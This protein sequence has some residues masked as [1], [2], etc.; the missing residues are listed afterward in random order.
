MK[1]LV[2]PIHGSRLQV[3]TIAIL[4]VGLTILGV[5]QITAPPEY[6]Q[7]RIG[8]E[9]FVLEI[10]AD[11]QARFMGLSGRQ[12]IDANSGMLFVYPRAEIRSFY[13]RDCPI[14]IDILF[15]DDAGA[16][17]SMYTMQPEA[18]RAASESASAYAERLRYYSSRAK[19]QYVI[20]LPAGTIARLGLEQA[21]RLAIDTESLVIAL[22]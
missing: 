9:E 21:D 14:P 6:H 7:L 18:P 3:R 15:L 5:L 17:V 13:M 11:D 22:R 12:S 20:E 8:A 1:E 2:S 19:A 10:A 4:I 16:I